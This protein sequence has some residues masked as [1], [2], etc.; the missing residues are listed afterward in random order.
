MKSAEEIKHDVNKYNKS[1]IDDYTKEDIITLF[2]DYIFES[3][4]EPEIVW[5]MEHNYG[6]VLVMVDS[7]IRGQYLNRNIR[8]L[9]VQVNHFVNNLCVGDNVQDDTLDEV[10]QML[11]DMFS[12]YLC[13]EIEEESE[14]LA[15]LKMFK[16]AFEVNGY[17]ISIMTRSFKIAGETSFDSDYQNKQ[18]LS[19]YLEWK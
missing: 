10:K 15:D 6:G 7:E 1:Y 18:A 8:L 19:I 12:P 4:L 11:V 16:S 3:I 2:A 14:L 17:T 13:Y 5:A 9:D